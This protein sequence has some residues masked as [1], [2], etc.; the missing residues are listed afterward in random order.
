MYAGN[1]CVCIRT[2]CD[3][4]FTDN[5]TAE[6]YNH[7][8]ISIVILA[9]LW[10]PTN[11][12]APLTTHQLL[13]PNYTLYQ[14]LLPT[15]IGMNLTLVRKLLPHDDLSQLLKLIRTRDKESALPSFVMQ[16]RYPM[17]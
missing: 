8:N 12:S 4:I 11:Y 9:E 3:S 16:K 7:S 10:D 13:Q 6:T 15:P 5:T 14:D 17:S 2:L 1:G